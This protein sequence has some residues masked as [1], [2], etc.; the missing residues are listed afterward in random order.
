MKK[1]FQFLLVV[2]ASIAVMSAMANTAVVMNKSSGQTWVK[3]N[4]D[5]A[6]LVLTSNNVADNGLML[7]GKEVEIP[8]NLT[9][10]N[11]ITCGCPFISPQPVSTGMCQV[12]CSRI[13][14]RMNKQWRNTSSF[15]MSSSFYSMD[16]SATGGVVQS[17]VWPISSVI[18]VNS[19]A[20][21][22]TLSMSFLWHNRLTSFGPIMVWKKPLQD[23]NTG[24]MNAFF[25]AQMSDDVLTQWQ[26]NNDSILS[27]A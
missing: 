26:N 8:R 18:N 25:N 17:V 10:S 1:L 9:V 4:V 13:V 15:C 16:N 21:H 11:T 27:L 24:M 22:S 6:R 20:G 3:G 7:V 23:V 5:A 2:I 19:P 12:F 14:M